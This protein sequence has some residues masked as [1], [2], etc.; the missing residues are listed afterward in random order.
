[1]KIIN[2]L[3]LGLAVV[4]GITTS[5]KEDDDLNI[6][7]GLSLD[8]EEIT[9]GPEKSFKEIMVKADVN[10]QA[11]SSTPWISISPANGT[12]SATCVLNIDST[13]TY[14][15]RTAQVRFNPAGNTPKI[16]K[17]TQF[18][19]GKQIILDKPEVELENSD[20]EDNRYFDVTISTNVQFAIESVNYSFAEEVP[21]EDEAGMSESDKANWLTL[22]KESDLNVNL[23]RGSRPR[24]VK[25]RFKW[26]MNAVP[27][28][29]VATIKLVAKN[30][31]DQLIDSDGNEIDGVYLTVTQKPAM[32][33]EDNRAGDS[34]SIVLINQKLQCMYALDVS[35]NMQNWTD[36]TLWEETDEDLPEEAAVGRVRSLSIAMIDT[37][38]TLPQEIK[39]L[40]YLESFHVQSN[41]NRQDR[42]IVLGPEIC[43]LKYL[44]KLSITSYG[45]VELPEEF[46][47][48]GGT[49]DKSYVGLEELGLE[50]NNF[51][52][53]S[54]ITDLVNKE[55]F[56]KLKYLRL[57]GCR[58]TDTLLDMS[59]MEGGNTWKGI[60]IGMYINLNKANDKNEFMKLL[61][62]DTL[63]QLELS[64]GFIEGELP[65]DEEMMAKFGNYSQYASKHP[66]ADVCTLLT[67]TCQWL[68]TSDKAVT[69]KY[70]GGEFSVKGSDVPCVLPNTQVLY[71]NLNFLT[72][73]VPNWILFHPHLIDWYPESMVF[74][75][76]EGK[77]SNG[78]VVGFSNV[79]M[80]FEY[81][82]GKIANDQNAAFPKYYGKYVMEEE[83]A[84]E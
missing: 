37:K 41:A 50:S 81:F 73:K 7:G 40:K 25:A 52:S 5:C 39:N 11:S 63:K 58:R 21:A 80:D 75:Q 48:L 54:Q 72:G 28:T 53:L 79:P 82:Y 56:P 45:L 33:I 2:R 24:S 15:A 13:L 64:Y 60:H 27:Y 36:V 23:D 76:E 32:K 22:P 67:D 57:S 16:L 30:S 71:L 47:K 35:E 31:E 70:D 38:E 34:I 18:G 19:F 62:W 66:D 61:E 12:G 26:E 77:N 4:A 43:E 49:V 55:N 65:T 44:K 3:I 68:K 17:V 51:A 8:V 78:E 14:T 1:M 83:T 59:Q 84:G 46:V 69:V 42:E 74:T 9:V 20:I 10:W 6:P 29:R